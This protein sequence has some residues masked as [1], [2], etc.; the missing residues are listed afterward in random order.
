VTPENLGAS[1]LNWLQRPEEVQALQA[2][3]LALHLELR[4][5]ASEQA[6]QAIMKLVR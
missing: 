2:R 1:V 4:K 6:A 3:F 5:N